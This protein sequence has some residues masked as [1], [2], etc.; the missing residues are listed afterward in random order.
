MPGDSGSM[1]AE[2]I[3]AT[4]RPDAEINKSV[5]QQGNV[6]EERS[7]ARPTRRVSGIA[8][9]GEV[10]FV[11]GATGSGLRTDG[12]RGTTSLSEG[13]AA[14]SEEFGEGDSREELAGD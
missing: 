8:I 13:E 5:V 4:L 11:T 7:V 10:P 2:E 3:A 6:T 12:A 1:R 14:D 9:E